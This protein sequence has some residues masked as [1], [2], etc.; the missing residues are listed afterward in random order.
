[1]SAGLVRSDSRAD[2]LQ[3]NQELASS[4]I[5]TLFGVLYE[6]YSSSVSHKEGNIYS[7]P[8]VNH[9]CMQNE[10]INLI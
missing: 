8:S 2:V 10:V 4:F 7:F 3:E 1:M 5:K 9:S 6:V